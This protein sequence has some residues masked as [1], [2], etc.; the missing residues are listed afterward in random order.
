MPKK[1]KGL[2]DVGRAKV[3]AHRRKRITPAEAAIEATQ[4]RCPE[5]HPL[6]YRTIHGSCTP[7]Y[8][9][10][11]GE[12]VEDGRILKFSALGKE[13]KKKSMERNKVLAVVSAEADRVI[14]TLIPETVPGWQQARAAAKE[15]K[16]EELLRLAQGIGR[17]AA[18]KTYFKVPEGLTGG[19][20]EEWVQKRSMELSVDALAEFERQLK[21]GDDNQR[22]D[23]ARDI[24]KMNGMDKKEAAQGSNAVIILNNAAGLAGLPWLQLP[25]LAETVT[26]EAS[27]ELPAN[28]EERS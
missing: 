5:G 23:A 24:L 7:V 15:Q 13:G 10:G 17:H 22:R 4:T 9:A 14:D 8:C 16:S 6:P 18:M 3:M 28:A 12:K 20:A 11:S 21:L 26:A 2:K 19:A 1:P 25:K 27:K